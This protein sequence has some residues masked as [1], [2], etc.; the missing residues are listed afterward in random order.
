MYAFY[1][2]R[3]Y[4]LDQLANLSYLERVFLHCA[5]EEHYKEETAKYKAIFGGK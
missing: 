4:T 2:V 3:G 5:R 1:S